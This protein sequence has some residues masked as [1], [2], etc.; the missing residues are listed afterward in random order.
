M[1]CFLRGGW[2]TEKSQISAHATGW[3]VEVKSKKFDILE[4]KMK[5]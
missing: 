3:K 2:E 5:N 1:F 4:V